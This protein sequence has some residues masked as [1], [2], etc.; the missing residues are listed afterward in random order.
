MSMARLLGVLLLIVQ[1]GNMGMFLV[2]AYAPDHAVIVAGVIGAIQA[3]VS[4]V[5]GESSE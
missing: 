3:F 5:Q 4:K 2:Q 1:L